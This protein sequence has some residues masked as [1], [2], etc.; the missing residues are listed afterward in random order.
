MISDKNV[1]ILT[2]PKRFFFE[3]RLEILVLC[4]IKK[5]K[6]KMRLLIFTKCEKYLINLR[7]LKF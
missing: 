5:K 1:L 7:K 6:K 2:I 3:N 4:V